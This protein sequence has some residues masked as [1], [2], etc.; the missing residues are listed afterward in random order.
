VP[1]SFVEQS[2]DL[3]VGIIQISEVHTVSRAYRHAGRIHSFLDTVNTEGALV[4]I[5]FRMD[6]T[7]IVGASRHTGFAADAFLMI[8][9]HDPASLVNVTGAA[10]T[11]IYARRIIA[12]IAAF[13]ADLHMQGGV[14]PRRVIGYPIPIE[15]VRHMVFGLAGYDAI[16]ATDT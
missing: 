12:V 8:D 4:R 1:A 7:C 11:A 5:T 2:A 14:S 15:S 9:E 3:A 16:H 6:K 13:A 10:G